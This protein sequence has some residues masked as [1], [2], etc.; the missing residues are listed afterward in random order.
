MTISIIAAHTKNMVIGKNNDLP[1][2]LPDDMNFFKEKTKHH[3]IIM[4][5]KNY[6]SIPH[7]W[8]PL[9][10]RDN[11]VVTRDKNYQADGCQVVNSLESAI[12]LAKSLNEKEIFIIGGGEVYKQGLKYANKMYLTEIN[13]ELEG[14]VFFPEYDKNIWEIT[15]SQHHEIDEKHPFDFKFVTYSRTF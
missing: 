6:E 2:H 14:D 13:T 1:W 15:D 4:G 10:F 7:K 5:R 8:R 9:P 11:I 12:D 3:P